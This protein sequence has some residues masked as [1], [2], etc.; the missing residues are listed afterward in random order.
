[1]PLL[2]AGKVVEDRW[3][4]AGDDEALPEGAPVIV[5]LAR[6]ERD[7]EA[8]AGR[9]A[10]VGVRLTSKARPEALEPFLDRLA[11]VEIDFPVFRD[12]RGF[13]IARTLRERYGFAGE[14][15][16]VGH[17]LLDQ[18]AYLLRTGFTAVVIPETAD[19]AEWARAL[20]HYSLGYQAAVTEDTPFALLRR[21]LAIAGER[22]AP[23]RD[24]AAE[25][26]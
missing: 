2:E 18:H 13:T 26:G 19:P 16:A 22:P 15:R 3:T 20:G 10:P 17:V 4:A 23:G 12:G 21:R 14:I 9:N 11:L 25:A 8:L 1:M 24:G 7:A 5:S 6:L